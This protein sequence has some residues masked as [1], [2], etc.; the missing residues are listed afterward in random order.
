MNIVS[1]F[2]PHSGK[3]TYQDLAVRCGIKLKV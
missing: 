3:T 2:E 1:P